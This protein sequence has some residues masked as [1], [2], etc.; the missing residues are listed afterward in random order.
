MAGGGK[1]LEISLDRVDVE[2]CDVRERFGLGEAFDS[3]RV[4]GQKDR[5][6]CVSVIRRHGLS[7]RYLHGASVLLDARCEPNV[8]TN[9]KTSPC[10]EILGRAP[11]YSLRPWTTQGSTELMSSS[12]SAVDRQNTMSAASLLPMFFE[13]S[14]LGDTW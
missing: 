9:P 10:E 3:Q 1:L 11:R 13:H 4:V 14:T 12:S 2:G 5:M 6:R 8:R 7:L